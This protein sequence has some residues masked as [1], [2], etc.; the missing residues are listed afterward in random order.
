MTNTQQKILDRVTKDFQHRG[1]PVGADQLRHSDRESVRSVLGTA[2]VDL[3]L[4]CPSSRELNHALNKLQEALFWAHA[5][6]DHWGE[7]TTGDGA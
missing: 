2:S 7:S 3:V 6:I 1:C 4:I 5:A